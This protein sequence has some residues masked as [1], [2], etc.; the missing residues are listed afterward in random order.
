MKL[1]EVG[2]ERA[3]DCVG[4]RPI[5]DE[6]ADE[7]AEFGGVFGGET[8]KSLSEAVAEVVLGGGCPAYL[9]GGT[10]RVLGIRAI[11]VTLSVGWH[12]GA[13]L[14][15]ECTARDGGRVREDVSQT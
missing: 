4:G 5:G 9:G 12:G 1:G 11:G 2:D 10:G 15:S 8:R 6:R 7:G 13:F 14:S 3:F